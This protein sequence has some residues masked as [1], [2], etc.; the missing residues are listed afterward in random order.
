MSIFSFTV[1]NE[2]TF[3]IGEMEEKKE[4]DIL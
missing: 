3:H 2:K 1:G 4:P